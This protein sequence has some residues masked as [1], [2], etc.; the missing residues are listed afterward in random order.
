MG[1]YGCKEPPHAITCDPSDFH[2]Q[3]QG[4]DTHTVRE[5][6]ILPH[7]KQP[8]AGLPCASISIE[9]V[10]RCNRA[11]PPPTTAATFADLLLLCFRCHCSI[12][13]TKSAGP[14]GTWTWSWS[15][16]DKD[17]WY[18]STASFHAS[19]TGVAGEVGVGVTVAFGADDDE[20]SA[21]ILIAGH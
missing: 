1:P 2:T 14:V 18:F 5:N 12:S 20:E 10:N 21:A 4:K 17:F 11:K 16:F 8:G 15:F 3:A 7:S 19:R 6:L 9:A 13:F